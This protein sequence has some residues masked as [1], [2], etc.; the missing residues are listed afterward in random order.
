MR[1]AAASFRSAALLF[2]RLPIDHAIVAV[3]GRDRRSGAPPVQSNAMPNS[4]EF[5]E[6]LTDLFGDDAPV[7][8]RRM[9][10]GA[11]VFRDGLMFALIVDDTLY[12]KADDRNRPDFEA[13]AMEPFTYT[14]GE[15]RTSMSYWACPPHL[16]EDGEAFADWSRKAFEAALAARNAKGGK[17]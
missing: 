1:P 5:I 10:G 3:A 17:R 11:G 7:T 13:A 16:L 4:P 15:K 14:R 6:H 2:S 8:V 9:F 12:F